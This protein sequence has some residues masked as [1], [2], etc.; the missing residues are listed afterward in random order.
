MRPGFWMAILAA[1]S[2]ASLQARVDATAAVERARYSFRVG[3][4]RLVEEAYPRT[5][6][7]A[8]VAREEAEE[9]VLQAAF[10]WI[11]TAEDLREELARIESSTREPEQWVAIKAVLGEDAHRIM[12]VVCRPIVVSRVLRSRFAFD[13]EIQRELLQKARLARAELRAGP[14]SSTARRIQLDASGDTMTTER[15][16]EQ[17]KADARHGSLVAGV[18]TPVEG[19]QPEPL[20]AELAA[21]LERELHEPGD[22][23]TILEWPDR[24]EVYRLVGREGSI[25]T[26][27]AV[28]VPKRDFEEWFSKQRAAL[29]GGQSTGPSRIER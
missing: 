23:T 3:A 1:S 16:L 8:R 12:E 25:W 4:S 21:V 18:P 29:D 5:V 11:P 26:V 13:H 14:S 28:R 17:A 7:E 22:V 19:E 20:P 6:F 27:D 24:F 15:W 10:G 9:E 2:S